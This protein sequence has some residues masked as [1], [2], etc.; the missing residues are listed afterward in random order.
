MREEG[1]ERDGGEGVEGGEDGD[2]AAGEGME[3][4]A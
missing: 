3:K 1:R 2:A 4:G